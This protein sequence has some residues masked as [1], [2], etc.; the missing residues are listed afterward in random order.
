MARGQ[1]RNPERE[2]FW[3]GLLARQAR[4][5]LS[6]LAFCKQEGVLDSSFYTWRRRIE[7]RDR[8]SGRPGPDALVPKRTDFM[9]VVLRQDDSQPWRGHVGMAP[10]DRAGES[11]AIELRN[12]RVMRLPGSMPADQIAAIV[13]ALEGK[14]LMIENLPASSLGKPVLIQGRSS[15]QSGHRRRAVHLVVAFAGDSAIE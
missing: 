12:G 14:P 10:P 1:R 8:E 15:R 13:Q 7:A 9:P 11:I 3:R 6:V 5:S 2:A 4:S